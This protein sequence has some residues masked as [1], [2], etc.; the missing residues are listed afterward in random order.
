MLVVVVVVEIERVVPLWFL[1][2]ADLYR[3]IVSPRYFKNGVKVL[4]Q[5]WY[6]LHIQPIMRQDTTK[7]NKM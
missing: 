4:R 7:Q 6:W 1:R 3:S 2:Y 5:A